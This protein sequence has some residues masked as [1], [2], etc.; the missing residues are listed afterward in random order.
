M[1]LNTTN[2]PP[3]GQEANVLQA[4]LGSQVMFIRVDRNTAGRK[5][6]K[7]GGKGQRGTSGEHFSRDGD[8]GNSSA[9]S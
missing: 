1:K 8:K 7:G 3:A 4:R 6:D 5:R 2:F 9:V